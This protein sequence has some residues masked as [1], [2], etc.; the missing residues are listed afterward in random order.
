[1]HIVRFLDSDGNE[2][3][4]ERVDGSTARLIEG[5]LYGDY[6]VTE[7]TASI[8]KLL[9]PVAPSTILCIGLNYRHHAQTEQNRDDVF[10]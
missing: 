6:R 8:A 3:H 5:D 4:G 9:A 7:Q 1:M 2:R 10:A